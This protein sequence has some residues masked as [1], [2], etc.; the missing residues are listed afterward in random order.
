[1]KT[2]TRVVVAAGIVS[3]G[4]TRRGTVAEAGRGGKS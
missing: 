3:A 4:A 1:M 2:S